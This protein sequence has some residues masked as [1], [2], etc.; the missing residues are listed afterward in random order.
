M[1]WKEQEISKRIR[2]GVGGFPGSNGSF[3]FGS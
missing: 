1:C 3:G 2:N